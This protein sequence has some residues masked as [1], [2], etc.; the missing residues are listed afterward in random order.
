MS[1]RRHY[2][3]SS[4]RRAVRYLAVAGVWACGLTSADALAD[5]P[6]SELKIVAPQ[7]VKEARPALLPAETAADANPAKLSQIEPGEVELSPPEN[8]PGNSTLEIR[9]AR[10][11]WLLDKLTGKKTEP[12]QKMN[13]PRPPAELPDPPSMS[14]IVPDI[15]VP[16]TQIAHE[17]TRALE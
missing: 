10:R 16:I 7:V 1:S 6:K 4:R 8:S 14:R 3:F 15:R 12:S 9:V 11:P 5:E 2:H 17:A 13:P